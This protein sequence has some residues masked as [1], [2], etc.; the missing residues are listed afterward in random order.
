MITI[1][2]VPAEVLGDQVNILAFHYEY[3]NEPSTIVI[4]PA[5]VSNINIVSSTDS[6]GTVTNETELLA[7]YESLVMRR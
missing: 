2:Y 7:Q 4:I 3:A 5:D 6:G 1:I